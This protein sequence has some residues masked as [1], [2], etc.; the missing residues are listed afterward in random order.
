MNEF[1]ISLRNEITIYV[2]LN[3]SKGQNKIF[4]HLRNN[5]IFFQRASTEINQERYKI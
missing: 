3:M 1:H 4:I 2:E 5:D